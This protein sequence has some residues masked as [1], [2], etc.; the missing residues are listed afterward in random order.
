M[1]QSTEIVDVSYG[2]LVRF[3]NVLFSDSGL[4]DMHVVGTSM[5]DYHHPLDARYD[6]QGVYYASDDA[7]Y[8]VTTAVL[9]PEKG[10]VFDANYGIETAVMSDC[11]FLEYEENDTMPRPGC[12]PG[13]I[14]AREAVVARMRNPD[15]IFEVAQAVYYEPL[16]FTSAALPFYNKKLPPAVVPVSGNNAPPPQPLYDYEY[17]H[18]DTERVFVAEQFSVHYYGNA[19]WYDDYRFGTGDYGTGPTPGDSSSAYSPGIIHRMQ[20]PT[21]EPSAHAY[22]DYAS[23]T[24]Q[25]MPYDDADS[26]YNAYEY[27]GNAALAGAPLDFEGWHIPYED[28]KNPTSFTDRL[29]FMS[30]PNSWLAGLQ[31]VRYC[32]YSLVDGCWRTCPDPCCYPS[33]C[34]TRQHGLESDV[35]SLFKH[36]AE[37]SG[38]QVGTPDVLVHVVYVYQG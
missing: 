17:Q 4:P 25:R 33:V 23:Y 34:A 20:E 28:L 18:P 5:N 11:L 31:Q 13:S 15:A 2:G 27:G 9:P 30:E 8:D 26:P 3:Q 36:K 37:E 12:P 7:T 21:Q 29:D 16:E 14:P 38:R 22:S 24:A 6:V 32:C 35:Y 19:H 10:G 1:K